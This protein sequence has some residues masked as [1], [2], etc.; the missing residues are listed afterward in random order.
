MIAF[1]DKD[2]TMPYQ[3]KDGGIGDE[4]PGVATNLHLADC[5]CTGEL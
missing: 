2:R 5:T 4:G 3:P 1:L